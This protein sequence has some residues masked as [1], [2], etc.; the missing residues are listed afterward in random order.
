MF[1][2]TDPQGSLFETSNLLSG[3]K[4]KRLE[5]TWAW[6]F[7]Q[8]ALS[9]IDENLFRE[10]YCADNG[11]PNKPGCQAEAAGEGARGGAC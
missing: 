1:R 9:L 10:L 11:C 7:R 3:E 5:V 4:L 6:Q 2:L 8:H